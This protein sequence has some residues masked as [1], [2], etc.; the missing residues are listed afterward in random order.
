MKSQYLIVGVLLFGL[1]ASQCTSKEV[2]IS[3]T[4]QGEI[5]EMVNYTLPI[6]G[7]CHYAFSESI[8]PDASGNFEIV[9]AVDKPSFIRVYIPNG[10]AYGTLLVESGM[11][12][13]VAFDLS[14]SENKF[15]VACDNKKGQDAFNLLPES[16]FIQRGAKQFMKSGIAAEIKAEIDSVKENEM[17]SFE[18]FV[19]DGDISEDFYQLVKLDRECYYAAIQGTVALIKNYEDGRKNNGVFTLEIKNMWQEAFSKSHPT[20]ATLI[21]SIW[22]NDLAENFINYNE[23]SD[24]SFDVDKLKKIFTDGLLHTHNI[25][26]SSKYLESSALEYYTASYLSKACLQKKY[27]KEL[28]T[29][30]EDFKSEFPNSNYSEFIEPMIIPIVE[31]HNKKAEAY[32]KRIKFIDEG[33]NKNSLRDLLQSFRGKK[34]FIDVWATWCG[35]CKEEFSHTTELKKLLN[36]YEVEL[37]YISI[38]DDKEDGQWKDMLKYYELEGYHIR[39]NEALNTDLRE[40]FDQAGAIAIPWYLL[41]DENG[42]IANLD[43]SKPS[44]LELLE[45]EL[46]E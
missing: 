37:L 19:L 43:A 22:Y 10:N 26:E 35:P 15:S 32:S 27:E 46:N 18:T 12:Y 2:R 4:I 7:V 29:L 33:E 20:N 16:H 23:Y 28:I 21:Q 8:T 42:D 39:A 1:L 13:E 36:S 38:D 44:N 14:L 24:D 30:F 6:H 31:F 25:E 11:S 45:I 9:L 3:G 34:V 5:P 41:I 40:V 17:K